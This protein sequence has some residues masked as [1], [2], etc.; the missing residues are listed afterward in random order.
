[1]AWYQVSGKDQDVVVSSSVCFARNLA[2]YPFPARLDAA[3]AHEIIRQVGAVLEENGFSGTDFTDVSRSMA[4]SL[5]EKQYV[6]PGFVRESIPH[7]LYLNEPCSL[8]VM[9]C[10][11]DHIRL[12]CLLPGFALR[13]AFAGACKI[14]QVLDDRFDLAFDEDVGYL[15]QDPTNAGTA[16]RASVTLFLPMTVMNGKMD[17]LS[18]RLGRIGLTIR[19]ICG[20]KSGMD[21]F[22]FRVSNRVTLG[23]TEE[24]VIDR[25]QDVV[26][27]ITE[28]ERRYRSGVTGSELASLTDR[29]LR[30][31]GVLKY[32]YR[33]T[34]GEFLSLSAYV[35]LGISMG[36]VRDVRTET[37]TELTVDM[38]PAS[39]SLGADPAPKNDEELCVLRA[40]RVRDRLSG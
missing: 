4:Y 30:A 26:G 6:T 28:T 11:R 10:E 17:I 36:I 37:L 27:R 20:E 8:S 21:G 29:V 35:R 25:M 16:M 23:V 19:P 18:E 39:L 38:M 2:E 34:A 22:L 31:E 9:L 5:V 7:A 40:A 33:M 24:A 13:D 32:A 3:G 12:Q 14:E 1:M 15:T